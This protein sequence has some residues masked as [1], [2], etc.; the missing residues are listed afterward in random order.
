MKGLLI[1]LEEDLEKIDHNISNLHENDIPVNTSIVMILN[2]SNKNFDIMIKQAS[3]YNFRHPIFLKKDELRSDI[4]SKISHKNCICLF[5]NFDHK[6]GY[7]FNKNNESLNILKDIEFIMDNYKEKTCNIT[8]VIDENTINYLKK[9]TIDHKFLLDN[10]I[11]QREITGTLTLNRM[12]SS[13]FKVSVNEK[14]TKI[15]G[16]EHAEYIETITSFHTHPFSAYVKYNVCIAFPSSDDYVTTLHI[17]LTTH[18]MFHILATLEGIY[19]ITLKNI[20]EERKKNMLKNFKKYKDYIEDYYGIDYP[21]CNP[22]EDNK[23]FWKK[24]MKNYIKKIN[25]LKYFNVQFVFWKDA[26]NP[27]DISYEKIKNNCILSDEQY[28]SFDKVL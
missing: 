25:K 9:Y 17:Y 24:Y 3:L 2:P 26:T 18:N 6:L 21:T 8:I 16:A 27:I 11:E 15:G 14:N 28:R 12:S 4:R 23:K 5:N 19:I 10:K 13:M 22:E 1:F 20:K 7:H